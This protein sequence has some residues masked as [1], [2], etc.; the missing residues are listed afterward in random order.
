MLT[1]RQSDWTSVW[2]AGVLLSVFA[3]L[4]IA[5]DAADKE[6]KRLEGTWKFVS[7]TSD[8]DEAKQEFIQKARWVIQGKTI[9]FPGPNEGKITFEVDPSRSPKTIDMTSVAGPGKTAE[10]IYKIEGERLMICLPGGKRESPGRPRP[11]EFSG[12]EGMSLLVLER[13]KE[14]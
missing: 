4:A 7:L 13:I 10:G 12:G 9:T 6:A 5:D 1:G 3:S 2:I 11:V 8:G 14:K